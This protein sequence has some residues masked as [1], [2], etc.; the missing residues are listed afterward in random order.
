MDIHTPFNRKIDEFLKNQ[1]N[2]SSS[3]TIRL[4][5]RYYPNHKNYY[6]LF[7]NLAFRL[8]FEFSLEEVLNPQTNKVKGYI[9]YMIYFKD[10][11]FKKEPG[12]ENLVRNNS[13]LTRAKSYELLAK[14]TLYRFQS[15]SDL[16]CYINK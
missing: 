15:V 6:S 13:I 12:R 14:E 7:D 3:E 9:P 2:S 11:F 8:G 5:K 4:I 10:N 1:P 16:E